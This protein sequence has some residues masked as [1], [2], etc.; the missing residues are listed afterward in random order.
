VPDPA[1]ISSAN[2]PAWSLA[3][4]FFFY[5]LFPV[6]Y[7]MVQR[8]S[9]A[10]LKRWAA[11][12]V[13]L[14]LSVPCFALLIDGPH[15][16]AELPIPVTQLWFGYLFPVTRLPEFVLG[17]VLARIVR[18]GLWR[19]ARARWAV[20]A[21]FGSLIVSLALPPIFFFGPF[22]AAAAG[23]LVATL[24]TR[25][26]QGLRSRVGSKRMVWLGDRSYALYMSHFVV[27]AF[28]RQ[29]FFPA[30]GLDVGQALLSLFLIVLPL[31]LV[32]SHV[33][34]VT[35]E[36]PLYNRFANPRV[37]QDFV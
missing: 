28:A 15:M 5:L 7:P 18:E 19:P 21:L 10:R 2:A 33:L 20:L 32:V 25:D 1:Y 13:L 27:I 8:I 6:L 36:R 22:Y 12:M 24:A 26:I 9:G 23:L 30:A 16:S 35:V 31:C 4:E 11:G 34:Y 3:C 17:M 37:R 14:S 29:L